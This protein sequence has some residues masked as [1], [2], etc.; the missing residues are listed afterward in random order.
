MKKLLMGSVALTLFSISILIFQMSC[1]KEANAQ[2]TTT[3]LTQQNLI[4][5]LKSNRSGSTT[6]T[7]TTREIWLANLDGTNQRKVPI[8]L[9]T[10]VE[11]SGD[12]KLT[13]DGKNIVFD[14]YLTT[15][16]PATY[17]Y[18]YNIYSCSID[19]SNV[20]KLMSGSYTDNSNYTRIYLGGAY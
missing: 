17:D 12:A 5:Y 14:A 6:T 2:T 19:G 13:P 20:K 15:S 9:P 10:G 1:K 8:I 4:V 18:I 11:I 16:S 3:G 7:N